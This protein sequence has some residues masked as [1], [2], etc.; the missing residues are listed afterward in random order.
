[1]LAISS[2]LSFALASLAPAA[3]PV[4]SLVT[5]PASSAAVDGGSN[6]LVESRSRRALRSLVTDL[7]RLGAEEEVGEL[8]AILIELGDTPEEHGKFEGKWGRELERA[9]N[10]GDAKARQRVGDLLVRGLKPI[11]KE[12]ADSEGERRDTLAGVLL[13]LDSANEPAHVALGHELVDGQ[14]MDESAARVHERARQCDDW[15]RLALQME[16]DVAHDESYLPAAIELFGEEARKVS[17]NGM[18]IHSGMAPEKL[19]RILKQALRAAAYSNAV[20]HGELVVPDLR[21][22]SPLVFAMD[23]AQYDQALDEAERNNGISDRDLERQ[24]SSHMAGFNDLRGWHTDRWGT[25]ARHSSVVIWATQPFWMSYESQPCFYEGHQNWLCLNFLGVGRPDVEWRE[26]SEI[27]GRTTSKPTAIE[28]ALW[29]S[30]ATSLFGCREWLR[31]RLSA[32]DEFPYARC[33]LP[34]IGMLADTTLLTATVVDEFLQ[35]HGILHDVVDATEGKTD[36][37]P[38]IEAALGETLP[39]FDDAW[40]AWLF[41]AAGPP[42]LLQ[43][44]VP[45]SDG[46][47]GGGASPLEREM[48][49]ALLAVRDRAFA[50]DNLWREELT[51][52]DD[53]SAGAAAHARYLTLNPEQQAAWPDA[54][55]EYPGEEGYSVEGSWAGLHSVIDFVPEPELAVERWMGTFYHRLPLLD[56][57]LFGIGYGRENRVSVLDVSSLVA[58]Y[59]AEAWVVWPADGMTDVARRFVPELPNPVPGEDQSRWGYPITLQLYRGHETGARDLTMTLLDDNDREVECHYLTPDEPAFPELAPPDA[60]CLIPKS[61]LDGNATY[62]VRASCAL[63]GEEKVWEFTTG[64]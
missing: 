44:I 32:G 64:R 59:W 46:G 15:R 20:L 60:Y 12:L 1:M 13:R 23:E 14:W 16:I 27:E 43:R 56:P 50:S 24:R 26:A 8:R 45:G 29:R 7:A 6:E 11:E 4:S 58:P 33:V 17:A 3:V 49:D 25:E 9:R 30:A 34:E 41:G 36:R 21:G 42:G 53:L 63:T 52:F 35:Q 5:D 37:V 18:S 47:S 2:I 22:A 57:G 55:E 48:L 31:S 61:K 28:E 54:H 40:Q 51:C 19:E 39:E 62:T 10:A 38:A